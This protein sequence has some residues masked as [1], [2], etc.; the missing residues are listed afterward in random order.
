[1]SRARPQSRRKLALPLA[2]VIG[3]LAVLAGVSTKDVVP[4]NFGVVDPGK[5]YRSGQMTPGAFERAHKEHGFKTIIDLGSYEPHE[6]GDRRNQQVA[7]ALGIKRYVLDLEGDATGNPNYYVQALR[8]MRNPANHP[9]LVHCGAGS[10]RTGCVM[11]L[12]DNLQHGTSVEAGMQSAYRHK[13]RDHRNP[14][15]RQVLEKWTDPITRAVRDG[16][17]IPGVEPLPEPR[18]VGAAQP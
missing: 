6:R 9:V 12:Y 17:Q 16:G 10:E 7:D 15:F 4:K 18:P 11:I 2:G 3:G 1:M 13:H 8:I 14:N 5:V